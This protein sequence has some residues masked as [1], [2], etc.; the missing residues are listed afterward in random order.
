LPLKGV[1]NA[2]GLRAVAAADRGYAAAARRMVLEPQ[3]GLRLLPLI[4]YEAIFPA[5][6][7]HQDETISA[8]INVTNDAWY[9]RTPGPYQHF[10]QARLRAV[11]QGLPLIRAANNG[12]SAVIDPQGRIVDH[13]LAL[14]VVGAV[15]TPLPEA[16]N[17]TLYSFH[18][19]YYLWLLVLAFALYGCVGHFGAGWRR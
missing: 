3:P 4:C 5:H 1:L 12:I 17:K 16:G 13:A 14:N 18:G 7:F 2:I 15:Q 10:H 6:S 19:R 9:G 11:E 8:L